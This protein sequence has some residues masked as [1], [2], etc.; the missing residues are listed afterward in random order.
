AAIAARL[1]AA[2]RF[3]AGHRSR[4]VVPQVGPWLAIRLDPNA[5]LP[6]LL[7]EIVAA[8]DADGVNL[9]AVERSRLLRAVDRAKVAIGDQVE[10]LHEILPGAV[11][12]R[13][14]RC[15]C[16]AR[17]RSGSPGASATAG[18]SS[19]ER[20]TGS[21]PMPSWRSGGSSWSATTP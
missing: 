5:Q 15:A 14:P 13:K 21:T 6:R 11:P 8:A 3:L 18:S 19:A 2:P 12:E 17:Y 7:D 4:A 20:S 16:R 10:W 1:E 9:P